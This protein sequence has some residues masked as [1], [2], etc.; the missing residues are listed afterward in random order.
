MKI[1]TNLWF[2]DAE[3][4]GKKIRLFCLPFA[5][6]NSFSYRLWKNH[7]P[8]FI[9]V[10]P[11]HLPGRTSRIG[12]RNFSDMTKLVETLSE[13]IVPLLNLPFA[14]FGHSMGAILSFELT[15]TL[16]EKNVSPEHLFVSGARAP[17]IPS[18]TPDLHDLPEAELKTELRK[19]NGTSPEVLD[20]LELFHLLLPTLRADFKLVETYKYEEKPLLKCPITAFGG[21]KDEE[22]LTNELAAWSVET[23]G[24]FSYH[25][26]S[27]DHFYFN[28]HLEKLLN[29][30]GAELGGYS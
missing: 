14:F 5:G 18:R 29:L 16:S 17:Q 26:F 12:E 3:T 27:G 8:D 11:V 6:G 23:K 28:S 22:V 20:N 9:G 24:T 10:C 30:I 2:P 7:L 15:R 1:N 4:K 21:D 13:E 25:I 19:L